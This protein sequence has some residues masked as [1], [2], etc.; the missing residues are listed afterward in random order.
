M[1]YLPLRWQPMIRKWFGDIAYEQF[2][3]RLPTFKFI[4]LVLLVV[5]PVLQ[6]E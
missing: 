1:A 5:T 6:N 4:N 3:A 2:E